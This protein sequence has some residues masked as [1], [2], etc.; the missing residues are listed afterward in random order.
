MSIKHSQ[1][2]LAQGRR[3]VQR[4]GFALIL[5]AALPSLALA[6]TTA[7][8]PKLPEGV[9][10]S[11]WQS[12]QGAWQAG[13]HAVAESVDQPGTW[14]ARNPGQQW[15]THF[16]G[17]G[18]MAQP[19]HGQWQWGLALSNWGFAGYPQD[20]E[21]D[22]TAR[23]E[24]NGN[25]TVYHWGDG[26]EEWFIN[27]QRG[28][29]HG[30]T[31]NQPPAGSGDTLR[32][33]LA[34]RGGLAPKINEG[35]RAVRFVDA[36]GGTALTYSGLKVW[37]ADG[38]LLD[39][40]FAPAG[41]L[42]ALSVDTR[43]ARYPI[44]I[45][46]LAQQAYLKASNTEAGDEFGFSVAV[47]G[48]TVVVGA[49]GEDS[50]ASG[51]NGD[52]ANNGAINAGAV[53]V[54]V[55]NAGGWI[56]QAYLKAS[57]TNAND[58]FGG[59][60]AVSGDTVVVGAQFEDSNATGVNGD[61][62][63]NAS[64]SSGAA[65]VFVRTGGVWSQQ[66][67]LKASNTDPADLFGWSVAVS[68]DTAVVGA[69]SE[70]SN[71]IGINGNQANN[72]SPGAGAA[73]VFVRTGGN[74]SQQEYLKASNTD[75]NDNF[76]WSV[77]VSGDTVVVAANGEDSNA[78]GVNNSQ[79]NNAFSNAGAAY[80]FV[81][82]A[83]VWS[84]QAY[85][86]ASNTEADDRFGFLVAVSGVTVVVGAQ[87][88]DSSA[89]GVNGD[90]TNN[91]ASFA[92]AAYVFVRA[93]GV[94]AQQAYLKASNTG[95][96]DEFGFSVAVSGDTVVVGA[97]LED[98]NASGVNGDPTN[99]AVNAAGAAYVF[100]RSAGNWSQQAYLKA[101]NTGAND[102]FGYSVAVSDGTVVVGAQREDSDATG[103]NANQTNNFATDAG[104]AY[105][106]AEPSDLI[107]ANGFQPN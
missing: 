71:A 79:V 54:F 98:S 92:G 69:Y 45:D 94:W 34:V 73:Y 16:D 8:A 97:R 4:I 107:F 7:E 87:L 32:F 74:W 50:G 9:T 15:L 1:L 102:F 67:Y 39:A 104:A 36:S 13:R 96:G 76:G 61:Q 41:D 42:L 2:S 91:G 17:R 72:E 10:Q 85:L 26:L 47:S 106:F 57:N 48:A 60:V 83:G 33:E 62:A 37:D 101:S 86:K 25:R 21:Q 5:S 35:A 70:D 44:T 46:P 27:D 99:N 66:A 75:P 80:V 77:A 105:I 63:N 82:N 84:Q 90:Q 53:Y 12:I 81:R 56:Q 49:P 95:A 43:G 103:V 28:L 40:A 64:S 78:T 38:K 3:L 20:I 59:S 65:Y 68:G 23:V 29:E 11:D 14:Q 55:R 18:F 6:K 24:I 30:Y 31:V 100:V 93:G 89:T 52:Q 58:F 51:I 19:D 88:E 22:A